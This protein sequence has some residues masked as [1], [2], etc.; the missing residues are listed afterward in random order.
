MK[1]IGTY[2]HQLHNIQKSQKHNNFLKHACQQSS[3][4]FLKKSSELRKELS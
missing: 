3:E 4:L 1:F 2:S